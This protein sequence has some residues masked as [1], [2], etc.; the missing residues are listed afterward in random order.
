MVA[1]GKNVKTYLNTQCKFLLVLKMGVPV[2]MRVF[3]DAMYRIILNRLV[4]WFTDV[5]AYLEMQ[6]EL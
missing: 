2:F 3:L 6:T 5:L 4:V 1:L